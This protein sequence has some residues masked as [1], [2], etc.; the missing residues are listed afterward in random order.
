M[1]RRPPSA[2]RTDP[3]FPYTTLFRSGQLRIVEHVERRQRQP[4]GGLLDLGL[5]CGTGRG[6]RAGTVEQAT[7][8][9]FSHMVLPLLLVVITAAHDHLAGDRKSTRLNSSH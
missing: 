9:Q 8:G 7:V 5:Q 2:T 3:L 4:V 1:I 6:E